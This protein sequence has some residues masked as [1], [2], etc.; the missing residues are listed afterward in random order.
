[1]PRVDGACGWSALLLYAGVPVHGDRLWANRDGQPRAPAVTDSLG[2]LATP[3]VSVVLATRWL[4]EPLHAVLVSAIVLILGGV[5]LGMSRPLR[6]VSGL[7]FG[8]RRGRL[9]SFS[10]RWQSRSSERLGE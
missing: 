3:V 5:A 2:L 6:A 1:M 10:D 8:R 4:G 7:R 9:R